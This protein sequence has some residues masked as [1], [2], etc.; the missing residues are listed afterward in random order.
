[1]FRTTID[2]RRHGL[3]H[4][5]G[6]QRQGQPGKH[7][8]QIMPPQ[9]HGADDHQQ[10]DGQHAPEGRALAPQ[11]HLHEHR[12]RDV[13]AGYRAKVTKA[14]QIAWRQHGRTQF[15]DHHL[16][17]RMR[18]AAM[19][20]RVQQLRFHEHGA[21]RGQEQKA[22]HAHNVTS[23]RRDEQFR[24][25]GLIFQQEQ[26]DEQLGEQKAVGIFQQLDD[27]CVVDQRIHAFHLRNAQQRREQRPLQSQQLRI[28]RLG[29]DVTGGQIVQVPHHAIA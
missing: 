23:K 17:Q 20:G 9:H 1:M 2:Q 21:I 12:H 7:I 11:I 24:P 27:Q 28:E 25:L 3:L 14:V 4:H 22:D 13:H 18:I 29:T 5:A 16:Q 26:H 8:N 6:D 10:I 19:H 15:A